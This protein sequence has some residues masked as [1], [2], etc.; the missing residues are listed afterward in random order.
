MALVV[1]KYGGTSVG[2][3]ERIRA[4]AARVARARARGD[5]L[6]VVVSAMG[7]TTD[8]MTTLAGEV[9]GR[10]RPQDEHPREMDMLL[11]AGER[12]AAALLTMAI[13]EAGHEARSFTGSQAAIITDTRHTTA[14]ILEVRADRVRQALDDGCI[15]IV[16]GFQGVS[17][18]KEIT[19]LGRGGS[20]TT[21]VALASALKADRCEIFT[22]VDGVFTADPR[23]VPG[24]RVI[25]VISHEEML[26]MASSGAQ[27]M[28]GRAVDIGGR[29]GVDIRVLS[30]FVDDD[31][32]RPRG[33]LITRKERMEDL[34]LKPVT[35]LAAKTGQAKLAVRG[36][37][38]GMR[39]QTELL[40]ALSAAG[41]SV[42]MLAE[43]SAGDG[44]MQV[45]LTIAE[46]DVEKAAEVARSAAGG[47]EVSAERGLARI[48]LVGHGMTGRPGVYARA[49]RTLLDLGVE[50]HGVSTSSTSIT[51]LVPR[52][53]ADEA[54][55]ALHHA[56]ELESGAGSS[57]DARA[58]T[59][60]AGAG[61]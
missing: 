30:S 61:A 17:T 23:K 5:D 40:E 6:V 18:E 56:F 15:A 24:A 8:E 12:I 9:T 28:H 36:L 4:V 10:E 29:T 60:T 59:A 39:A 47:A 16:A 32:G 27:V 45:Q 54:Q 53:R 41:V 31:D 44:R 19:T 51:V 7:H 2:T 37:E 11:T 43:S 58:E 52:D 46:E 14:R 25:P 3:P 42:D 21:A 55:A 48:A 57:A 35:G 22:D 49:Y 33:T 38:P 20:D 1:Q 13:R 34:V 26:E 50:V